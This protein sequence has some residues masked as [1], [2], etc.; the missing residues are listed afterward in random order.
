MMKRSYINSL[1]NGLK[2]FCLSTALLAFASCEEDFEAIPVEQFTEDFVFSTT[3]S[4]GVQARQN[5]AA[6]YSTM[7]NR[8]NRIG[9]DYLDAATDDA[10]SSTINESDVDRLAM[11]RYTQTNMIGSVMNL[12]VNYQAIRMANI[13][14]ANI[15]KVPLKDTFGDG[16]P[17][18]LAWKNEARFIRAYHYFELLK[19]FGGMPLMG[20]T[21]LG[22]DD[23]LELPRNSF[24]EC[25]EY[26]ISELEDIEDGLRTYPLA[27][28]TSEA[29]VVTAE[30]AMALRVRVLLYAAS[31]LFNGGNIGQSAEEKAL[32][33]YA[34]YDEQR[35]QRAADAARYFMDNYGHNFSLNSSFKDVFIT[36]GNP[37]IIFFRQGGNNTNIEATNGP[38]GYSGNNLGQGRTSPS[39]N[40]VD[41]FL[42]KDGKTIDDPTSAY[43]YLPFR[44]YENRDPR[45]K[46][47]VL[48]NTA[49]WLN[50][51]IETFEGGKDN[52]KGASQKTKTSYYMRKFMGNFENQDAYANVRHNWIELRYA[53]VLMSF[54]EAQNEVSGPTSE[55]EDVIFSIRERAGIDPGSDGRFGL[56]QGLTKEAMR[57]VI[58]NEKR[59]EFAFEEHRYWDLRRWK[60]A[61]EVYS[62]ENPVRGL[63]L[64]KT[65]TGFNVNEVDLLELDFEERRYF[66]PIPYSEILNNKN[67][68]Q[69]P[70]W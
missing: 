10:I 59:I 16:M 60:K 56:Q 45:L 66:Y 50:K 48:H 4:L 52:P 2:V 7:Y 36:D 5:L 8:H 65:P 11:G 70:G 35:W 63:V 32:L 49:T 33:G 23:D 62:P 40:L 51:E 67:M 31:P 17:L 14:I 20:D 54:A 68:V 28:L 34:Q 12:A 3:D 64:V 13:F 41:A 15:D 30:A 29:H 69:N 9:G 37:E 27:D 55:V 57:E 44:P 24:E 46:A 42:M 25:L 1:S 47:T 38:V 6:I 43:S 18:N 21:I 58:Q 22:L 26:I 19:R 39:Q 61:S 53:E